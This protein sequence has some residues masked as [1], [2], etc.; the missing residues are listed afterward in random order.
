MVGP[1]AGSA[2]PSWS[3]PGVG[4]PAGD[5]ALFPAEFLGSL[6]FAPGRQAAEDEGPAIFLGQAVQLLVEQRL[7]VAPAQVGGRGF[8]GA[9]G[10]LRF[11]V[12]TAGGGPAR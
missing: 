12:V 11:V 3:P 5:G 2:L 9:G 7:Q 8:R 4:E 1:R 6:A 10:G